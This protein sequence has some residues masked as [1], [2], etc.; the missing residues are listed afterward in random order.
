[1][2]LKKVTSLNLFVKQQYRCHQCN[3]IG[4]YDYEHIQF[5]GKFIEKPW[6][7][8][9]APKHCE[10]CDATLDF[11]LGQGRN[12]W[13]DDWSGVWQFYIIVLSIFVLFSIYLAKFHDIQIFEE[14]AR[15]I[16]GDGYEINPKE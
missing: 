11:G 2:G 5:R 3:H 8:K 7:T 10:K 12:S 14:I 13:S 16:F 9:S 4:K 15:F 1:M 6:D